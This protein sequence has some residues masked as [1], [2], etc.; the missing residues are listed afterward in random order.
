MA[1][2]D[3]HQR[4]RPTGFWNYVWATIL[5]WAVDMVV[6]GVFRGSPRK[7]SVTSA[8][9]HEPAPSTLRSISAESGYSA[10]RVIERRPRI[11][12][13]WRKVVAVGALFAL[14]VVVAARR[15]W[16]VSR[17][18]VAGARAPGRARARGRLPVARAGADNLCGSAAGL[19][20]S[21]V[22][23]PLDRTGVVP[24]TISLHVEECRRTASSAA[25]SS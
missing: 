22:V 6:D 8:T 9:A 21:Q 18:D 25:R 11:G 24:G 23:V 1:D 5:V 3:D 15:P 12:G 13:S 10:R 7:S 4:L 16:V 14:L 17:G 20:C 19:V 2:A